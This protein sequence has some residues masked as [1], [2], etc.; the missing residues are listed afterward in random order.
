MRA[1]RELFGVLFWFIVLPGPAG[2]ILYRLAGELARRWGGRKDEE[3]S[4]F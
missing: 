3:F 2:A 4:A 1:H